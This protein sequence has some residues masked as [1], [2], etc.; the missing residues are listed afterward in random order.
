MGA[1][2]ARSA[3]VLVELDERL[4]AAAFSGRRDVQ[5]SGAKGDARVATFAS[6]WSI[7]LLCDYSQLYDGGNNDDRHVPS[8]LDEGGR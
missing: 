8:M 6:D 3:T 4:V 5:T 1:D 2:S 7:A